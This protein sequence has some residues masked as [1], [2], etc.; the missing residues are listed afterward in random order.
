MGTHKKR[1]AII[2]TVFSILVFAPTVAIVIIMLLTSNGQAK[3]PQD[4]TP[5]DNQQS[6]PSEIT[7]EQYLLLTENATPIA[8]IPDSLSD[9]EYAECT[10]AENTYRFYL[11][12]DKTEA[13]F[14]VNSEKFYKVTEHALD[15]F[16]A[17]LNSSPILQMIPTLNCGST[18]IYPLTRELSY[19]S[20]DGSTLALPST[21]VPTESITNTSPKLPLAFNHAPTTCT[22]FLYDGDNAVFGGSLSAL[23]EVDISVYSK[24]TCRLDAEW[25]TDGEGI[26]GKATYCFEVLT[27]NSGTEPTPPEKTLE[28]SVD[29]DTVTLGEYTV[30]RVKNFS[31]AQSATAQITPTLSYPL[32]LHSL[33]AEELFA[34]IA[35][36]LDSTPATYTVTVTADGKSQSVTLKTVSRTVKDRDYEASQALISISRSE[37]SLKEY[38]SVKEAVFSMT[39]EPYTAIE[40]LNDYTHT[41]YNDANIYLGFGHNRILSNGTKYQM[42][43][44]DY[45]LDNGDAA[46][47][48]ADGRVLHCGYSQY[49]GYYVILDHGAGMRTWYARLSKISVEPGSLVGAGDTVGISGKSGFTTTNGVYLM[50]TVYNVHVSPYLIIENG[51]FGNKNTAT[52]Q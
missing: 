47:A 50:C 48:V 29:T 27:G 37:A 52:V 25:Y 4:S 23:A 46:I 1:T 26:V 22:V 31:D 16:L 9:S 33:N 20:E 7:A 51:F 2:Y 45:K 18:P 40:T 3:D 5:A 35:F 17:S 32:T 21:S 10:V 13:A 49:L 12:E 14:T 41:V 28:V 11:S 15:A 38:E 39:T 42:D 36:P 43:G 44:V 6:L 19:R 30:L 34:L 24:L 8:A